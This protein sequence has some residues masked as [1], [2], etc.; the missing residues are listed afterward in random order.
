MTTESTTA[1]ATRNVIAGLGA[2]LDTLDLT[3]AERA[4]LGAIIHAAADPTD[5]EV[6]GF[7][8]KSAGY[9]DRMGALGFTCVDDLARFTETPRDRAQRLK[10]G[11]PTN[12]NFTDPVGDAWW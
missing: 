4:A 11:D 5:D 8:S 7:G 1:T 6:S 2:K 3:T 9:R 10:I 12:Q